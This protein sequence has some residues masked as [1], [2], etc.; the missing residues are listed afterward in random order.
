M[1][2]AKASMSACTAMLKLRCTGVTSTSSVT[3][4]TGGAGSVGLSVKG[5]SSQSAD[6]LKVVDDGMKNGAI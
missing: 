1:K 6:M 3:I 2:E 4:S 5:A